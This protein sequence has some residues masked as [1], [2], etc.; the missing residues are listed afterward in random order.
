MTENTVA[1]AE[2]VEVEAFD[3][4]YILKR[5]I[6]VA[7][8]EITKVTIVEPAASALAGVHL[9]VPTKSTG[10]LELDIDTA[11]TVVA[12]CCSNLTPPEVAKLKVIDLAGL[13]WK[14]VGLFFA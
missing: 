5:P 7:D 2:A 1:E 10:T 12:A 14:C 8:R 11:I 13:Y 9:N 6:R 4:V 3:P